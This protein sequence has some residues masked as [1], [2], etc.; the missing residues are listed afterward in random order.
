MLAIFFYYQ[1]YSANNADSLANALMKINSFS[2]FLK[3][4]SDFTKMNPHGI[5]SVDRYKF[6]SQGSINSESRHFPS[7]FKPNLMFDNE[8]RYSFCYQP[9]TETDWTRADSTQSTM[10]NFGKHIGNCWQ[11]ES[12]S[13][14]V[15]CKAHCDQFVCYSCQSLH[16][17]R[18]IKDL[19][20]YKSLLEAK[21]GDIRKYLGK[22]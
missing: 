3:S 9:R 8:N 7:T 21:V 16:W 4:T 20:K 12:Y 15:H 22:I 13:Y 5:S 10:S 1:Y 19:L 18:E 2:L 17:Q 6:P 11:C 14:L